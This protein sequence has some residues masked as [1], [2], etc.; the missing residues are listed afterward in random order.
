MRIGKLAFCVYKLKVFVEAKHAL[1]ESL[2]INAYHSFCWCHAPLL[3]T[4]NNM[5]RSNMVPSPPLFHAVSFYFL[6]V[7]LR[8]TSIALLPFGGEE[9]SMR[10][11][12]TAHTKSA[13]MATARWVAP[14]FFVSIVCTMS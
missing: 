14:F 7:H 13:T 9:L 3:T 6:A 8:R 1:L 5:N 10:F 12:G 4:S 11:V 2:S